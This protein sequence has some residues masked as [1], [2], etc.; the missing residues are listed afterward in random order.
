MSEYKILNTSSKDQF[1]EEFGEELGTRLYRFYRNKINMSGASGKS[2]RFSLSERRLRNAK[3]LMKTYGAPAI[4]NAME[5][6]EEKLDSG[7]L[8]SKSLP[9]F[10]ALVKSST[11]KVTA[12]EPKQK[13]RVGTII[14]KKNERVYDQF[15]REL[16][17]WN[18]KCTCDEIVDPWMEQCPKCMVWLGWE[19]VD[20]GECN[21]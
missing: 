15:S 6:F 21:G 10:E 17:N 4:T 2:K 7:V 3:H 16:L 19:K 1:I 13:E 9:Y 20:L 12:Q 11:E 8:S 14:P 5:I 18:F